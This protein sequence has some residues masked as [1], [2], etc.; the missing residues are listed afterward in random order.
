VL[1]LQPHAGVAQAAKKRATA[2]AAAPKSATAASV[3]NP[4]E[5][6]TSRGVYTAAQ[7]FR[8]QKA[9]NTRCNSCHAPTAYTDATFEQLYVGRSAYALV[10][11]LR[12]TMPNDDPGS[13]TNQQYVDIVAYLF[14]LNGYPAGRRPL[15]TDDDTLKRV[16]IDKR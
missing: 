8:G 10:S 7:A 3:R 4:P 15:S 5:T 6:S 13:L 1:L 14:K 16:R 9:Y 2:A 11:L 12:Q